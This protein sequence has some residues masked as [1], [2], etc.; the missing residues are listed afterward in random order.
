MTC[1]K[2]VRVKTNTEVA[3]RRYSVKKLF[4]ILEKHL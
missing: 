3:T 2:S 1:L 4:A